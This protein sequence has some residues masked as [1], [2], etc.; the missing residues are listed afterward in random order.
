MVEGIIIYA[1]ILSV[2]MRPD[3]GPKNS[4]DFLFDIAFLHV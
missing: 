3:V 2:L 1:Q 4:I